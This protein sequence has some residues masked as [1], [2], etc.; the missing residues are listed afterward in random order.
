[1]DEKWPLKDELK[2]IAR[3]VAGV[4]IFI[5]LLTRF[6]DLAG[7]DGPRERLKKTLAYIE[8]APTPTLESP[9]DSL[10][11]FYNQFISDIPSPFFPHMIHILESLRQHS[12][13]P[14]TASRIA[15]LLGIDQRVIHPILA[16]LEWTLNSEYK[17]KYAPHEPTYGLRSHMWKIFDLLHSRG[18]PLVTKSCIMVVQ[19]YLSLFSKSPLLSTKPV[20]Q[21]SP[22][23]PLTSMKRITGHLHGDWATF[24]KLCARVAPQEEWHAI[25]QLVRDFDFRRLA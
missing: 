19:S 2:Q 11:H 18:R 3:V 1:M 25:H 14:P 12:L 8:N 22:D 9:Y 6:I 24:A 21:A 4:D 13:N 20:H 7:H 5:D 17:D 15:H 23:D 16:H 10:I